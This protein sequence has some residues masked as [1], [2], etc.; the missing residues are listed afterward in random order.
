MQTNKNNPQLNIPPLDNN[1]G[2]LPVLKQPLLAANPLTG[3][4]QNILNAL[5]FLFPAAAS[6]AGLTVATKAGFDANEYWSPYE[7]IPDAA[8]HYDPTKAYG[9]TLNNPTYGTLE[10]GTTDASVTTGNQYTAN[11]G[12]TRNFYNIV[13]PVAIIDARQSKNIVKTKITGRDGSIKEYIGMNDWAITIR[14]VVDMPADQAPLYFLQSFLQMLVAGVSIPVKNYYLNA[15]GISNIV[16]EDVD[17]G[18]AEGGYSSQ[19]LTITCVSDVP[20][21]S[22]LP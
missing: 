17:L 9:A 5:Q 10:L 1:A 3:S 4:G 21:S 11:D 14:S 13:F 16:I 19:P 8:E 15:L 22:F 6:Q 7:Y 20:L 18:Q 2:P 12:K